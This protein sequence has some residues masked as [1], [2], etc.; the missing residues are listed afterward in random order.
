MQPHCWLR[1][2]PRRPPLKF[3]IGVMGEYEL[4]LVERK[5]DAHPDVSVRDP[6]LE[7][8]LTWILN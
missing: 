3:N 7:V 2:S 5:Y 6:Q 8:A 4:N 1:W